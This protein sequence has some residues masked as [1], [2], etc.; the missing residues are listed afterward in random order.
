MQNS[1][2]NTS[3]SAHPSCGCHGTCS[4]C[5]DLP[6]DEQV[7]SV[8]SPRRSHHE[9]TSQATLQFATAAAVSHPAAVFWQLASI[10]DT[11]DRVNK[12]MGEGVTHMLD[13][14]RDTQIYLGASPLLSGVVTLPPGWAAGPQVILQSDLPT[15]SVHDLRLLVEEWMNTV[16]I[17]PDD[18]YTTERGDARCCV[19]R[20]DFPRQ[21]WFNSGPDYEGFTFIYGA[22]YDDKSPCECDCCY[23]RKF[24]RFSITRDLTL[25]ELH[26]D[27]GGQFI[28]DCL[29]VNAAG[30]IEGDTPD[31]DRADSPGDSY[32][33]APSRWNDNPGPLMHPY[34]ASCIWINS[35]AP[36]VYTLPLAGVLAEWEFL[37]VIYDTCKN[38]E[39]RAI[40][41]FDVRLVGVPPFPPVGTWR[42]T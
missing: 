33:C 39:I 18:W 28:E 40:K 38:W 23:F 16:K 20:F 3:E 26:T 24:V 31:G 21:L 1:Q 35:D 7:S 27:S 22:T 37:G 34:G 30:E 25:F 19:D 9:A 17:I 2:P 14:I 41:S 10:A 11:L 42:R 32:E 4:A 29:V 6:A 13:V 5:K 36:K 8:R 15:Q 12:P